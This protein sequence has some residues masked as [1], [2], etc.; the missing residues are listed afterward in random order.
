MRNSAKLKKLLEHNTIQI[1]LT[2]EGEFEAL[3]TNNI[4]SA[5]TICTAT[6]FTE[7]INKICKDAKHLHSS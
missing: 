3:V 6:N 1:S 5:S 4:T 7:L 2:D